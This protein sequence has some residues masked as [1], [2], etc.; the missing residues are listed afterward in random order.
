MKQKKEQNKVCISII[1]DAMHK[2][3]KRTIINMNIKDTAW[4]NKL[5]VNEEVD[6]FPPVLEIINITTLGIWENKLQI[7][8]TTAPCDIKGILILDMP[9]I[10]KLAATSEAYQI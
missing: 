7:C 4:L 2:L 3:S 5:V 9:C 6:S 1:V 8:I 10:G